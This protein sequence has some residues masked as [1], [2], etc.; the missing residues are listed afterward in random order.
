[1]IH[2][3]MHQLAIKHWDE[4]TFPPRGARPA[5]LWPSPSGPLNGP[6]LWRQPHCA[7][8]GGCPRCAEAAG[9][10]ALQ[11]KLRVSAP[12]D[13]YEQEADRA[14]ERVMSMTEPSH[15]SGEVARQGASADGSAPPQV[16]RQAAD[17]E[18]K[19]PCDTGRSDNIIEPAFTEA[20]RW[21]SR[22]EAW[23]ERHLD[24]IRQRASLIRHGYVKLGVQVFNELRLLERHFRISNEMRIS[25]PYSADDMVTASDLEQF[26]NGSYWVRRRFREVALYPTYQCQTNCPRGRTGSDVLGS[27]VPGSNDITFYTNCYDGQHET[28][29]AGVALHEAFHASFT[30]F[31]HDTYSF[32][33]SYPGGDGLTNAESFATFAANVATGG[34]YRIVVLPT[35]TIHGG[36]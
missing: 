18:Q 32:E 1:M 4:K 21:L 8:G 9:Q 35:M 28:T 31:N 27:A 20:R 23:L 17:P 26:G 10:R 29:R 25:F 2:I 11:P 13:S 6:V 12:G 3:H 33:S 24:H 34:N 30:E 36:P 14:A 22:T 7:C 15:A 19:G 16:Q 5:P